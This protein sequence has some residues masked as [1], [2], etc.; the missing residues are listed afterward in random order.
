MSS[1]NTF[2]SYGTVAKSFHWATVLL[3][4]SAFPI[5]YVA[6]E[7]AHQI[8]QADFDGNPDLITRAVLLFSIHKTLGVAAFFTALARILWAVTQEKPGLLHPD[9]KPEALVGEAVHWLLYLLMV[10]VPLSGWVMHASEVGYAPIWWPFGQDLPFVPKSDVVAAVAGSVHWLFV[11]TL[12]G[13]VG[14]HVAGALK[15]HLIDKD[16]TLLR[17]LPF[18]G[19]APVPP[20]Q[21]HDAKPLVVAVVALV[22]VLAVGNGIGVFAGHDHDHADHDHAAAADTPPQ[23]TAAAPASSDADGWTVQAGTLGID[24]IQGGAKVDGTFGDWVADITFTDPDAPG[25]AG[26]VKVTVV[27]A[28]LTLG[29]V[30]TQALGPDYFHAETFP[31]AVFDAKIEKLD[32]GY[33]A[34]G[35][36]TIRDQ[37]QPFTL[38]F[39]LDIDGNTAKMVGA[40]SLQRLDYNVGLSQKD[41]STVGFTVNIS[42]NLTAVRNKAT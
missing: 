31:T 10:L 41:E 22:A 42:V 27:I 19:A 38:P 9:N 11:W 21:N 37:S 12:F 14:L 6:N 26:T 36:L 20:A 30:T 8:N 18:G 23:Q 1:K 32:E 5:G 7:L 39:D 34:V 3:I 16:T 35:T 17:M 13:V 24:V 33:Q 29:S 4:F 28:S 25:P 40:A 15:H 2:S